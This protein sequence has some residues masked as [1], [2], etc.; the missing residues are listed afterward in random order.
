MPPSAAYAFKESI[1]LGNGQTHDFAVQQKVAVQI[2]VTDGSVQFDGSSSRGIQ[3]MGCANRCYRQISSDTLTAD[4]LSGFTITS[5]PGNSGVIARGRSEHQPVRVSAILGAGE[6]VQYSGELT[7]R[8]TSLSDG[9]STI[10][11][12]TSTT[13][14][15]DP[16]Q[17]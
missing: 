4:Q 17:T 3:P 11:V 10:K 14:L 9:A 2:E 16:P 12:S 8:V 15:P 1:Q 6:F 7:V 5:G 13:E